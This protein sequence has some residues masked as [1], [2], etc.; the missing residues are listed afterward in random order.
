[1]RADGYVELRRFDTVP[2]AQAVRSLLE[3]EGV[4]C[5]LDPS[6]PLAVAV[7]SGGRGI[8]L[9]VAASEKD[10]AESILRDSELSDREL[11]YLATGELP[12]PSEG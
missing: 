8:R 7:A 9:Y 4:G 3:A 10:R 2:S 6:E 1:M 5:L 12:D 11:T